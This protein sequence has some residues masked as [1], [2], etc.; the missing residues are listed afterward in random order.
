MV[1]WF[2]SIVCNNK[3]TWNNISQSSTDSAALHQWMRK[4]LWIAVRTIHDILSAPCIE[5]QLVTQW[6][7]NAYF[8]TSQCST[9]KKGY[10]TVTSKSSYTI[11][12]KCKSNDHILFSVFLSFENMWLCLNSIVIKD[13]VCNSSQCHCSS[14]TVISWKYMPIDLQWFR[15]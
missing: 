12:L 15:L 1:N 6:C 9:L 5:I 14:N 2:C 10:S 7:L 11:N 8:L 3:R 13:E 4:F